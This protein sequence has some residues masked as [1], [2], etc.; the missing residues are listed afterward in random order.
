MPFHVSAN[1]YEEGHRIETGQFGRAV[2]NFRPGGPMPNENDIKI[3]LFEVALE[4]S[5]LAMEPPLQPSRLN[6]VFAYGSLPD[7]V[8]FRDQYRIGGHIYE[9]VPVGENPPLLRD[10]SRLSGD[11]VRGPYAVS[12]SEAAKLYW[13]RTDNALDPEL[14]Y[15]CPLRVVRRI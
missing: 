2:K 9:V 6:C 11:G 3:L 5:R 4:A 10:A 7:A 12:Y 15:D 13:Q 1:I 14:L 8:R